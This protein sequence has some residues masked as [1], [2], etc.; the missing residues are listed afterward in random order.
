MSDRIYLVT[1]PDGTRNLIRGTS[2]AQA[3]SHVSRKQYKVRVASQN[4][5]VDA[6]QDG[7]TVQDASA[8]D[9]EP[10]QQTA[11]QQEGFPNV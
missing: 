10:E 4:D 7:I 3:R 8:T 9:S 5:L 11:P 2:P 1:E 6:L